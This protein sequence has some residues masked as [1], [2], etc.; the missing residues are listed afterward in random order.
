MDIDEDQ[1]ND[2]F[3]SI[4]FSKPSNLVQM[5]A[6]FDIYKGVSTKYSLNQ[7]FSLMG[8]SLKKID[9]FKTKMGKGFSPKE[10]AESKLYL[11]SHKTEI[12]AVLSLFKH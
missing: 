5:K 8:I 1:I 3:I 11:D 10:S 9:S 7:I 6:F 2:F 12:Q 4:A